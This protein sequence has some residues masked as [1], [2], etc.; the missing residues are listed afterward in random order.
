M[1]TKQVHKSLDVVKMLVR[2]SK[3]VDPK[4][5]LTVCSLAGAV[6]ALLTFLPHHHM[7]SLALLAEAKLDSPA[8]ILFM[9]G[10]VAIACTMV[11]SPRFRDEGGTSGRYQRVGDIIKEQRKRKGW[12]QEQLAEQLNV[13]PAYICRL[14]KQGSKP[15]SNRLCE[16]LARIFS[17]DRNELLLRAIQERESVPLFELIESGKDEGVLTGEE[18]RIVKLMRA[19]PEGERRSVIKVVEAMGRGVKGG[20]KRS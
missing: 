2:S 9:F 20:G 5:L 12:S 15:P 1:V 3:R 16:D 17:I 19:L 8:S 4:V 10:G 18:Q 11:T 13:C 6:I 14:E 7:G